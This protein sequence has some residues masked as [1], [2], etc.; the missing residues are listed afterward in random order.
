MEG[1]SGASSSPPAPFRVVPLTSFFFLP[2]LDLSLRA[3]PNSCSPA[4]ELRGRLAGAARGALR[5]GCGRGPPSRP[6]TPSWRRRRRRSCV[7]PAR[8]PGDPAPPLPLGPKEACG[9]FGWMP[10]NAVSV[11]HSGHMGK[12]VELVYVH[13]AVPNTALPSSTGTSRLGILPPSLGCR[14]L[15]RW[16]VKLVG[17]PDAV[18]L[19]GDAVVK[20]FPAHQQA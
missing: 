19:R 7:L 13:Q 6:R 10:R 16:L 11:L 20:S 8:P 12:V 3:R 9:E 15:L 17:L 4:W 18:C 14:V 2:P 5:A 1:G